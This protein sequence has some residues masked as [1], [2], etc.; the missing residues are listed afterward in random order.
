MIISQLSTEITIQKLK[1]KEEIIKLC[2]KQKH[3]KKEEE[4]RRVE[5]IQQDSRQKASRMS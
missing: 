3:R 4:V 5:N 1:A 2:G